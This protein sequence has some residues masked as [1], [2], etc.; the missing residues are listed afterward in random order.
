M[1]K[2]IVNVFQMSFD[3]A[4]PSNITREDRESLFNAISEA[5][6]NFTNIDGTTTGFRSIGHFNDSE[7]FHAYSET[8]LNEINEN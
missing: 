4:E 5:I 2:E 6:N 8:I 3:I 7:M 1:S